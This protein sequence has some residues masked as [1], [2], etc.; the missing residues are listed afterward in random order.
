MKTL[1]DIR[2]EILQKLIWFGPSIPC[3][4]SYHAGYDYERR[5]MNDHGECVSRMVTRNL[6]NLTPGPTYEG[7]YCYCQ[8][9]ACISQDHGHY[10]IFEVDGL[11]PY[12]LIA[13]GGSMCAACTMGNHPTFTGDR[14]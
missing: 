12:N 1:H 3:R 11:Y 9:P 13:S 8:S 14:T 5:T 10:Y 4:S 2:G 7:N 6:L